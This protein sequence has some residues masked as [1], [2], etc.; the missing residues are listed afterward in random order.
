[1]KNKTLA[2]WTTVS[3]VGVWVTSL[4]GVDATLIGVCILAQSV[5]AIMCAV[6]L[7]KLVN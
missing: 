7:N 4:T 1:M 2:I 3:S 6:R 5:F